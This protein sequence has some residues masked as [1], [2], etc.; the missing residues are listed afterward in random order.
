MQGWG[1]CWLFIFS[2]KNW[3]SRTVHHHFLCR[4]GCYS[5]RTSVMPPCS[6]LYRED[7]GQSDWR[8]PWSYSISQMW[9]FDWED[10]DQYPIWKFLLW[11]MHDPVGAEDKQGDKYMLADISGSSSILLLATLGQR[12]KDFKALNS[13]FQAYTERCWTSVPDQCGF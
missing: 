13:T 3:L 11:P 7:R 4:T 12:W 2:L 5:L 9:A 8:Y 1:D 10:S 6:W